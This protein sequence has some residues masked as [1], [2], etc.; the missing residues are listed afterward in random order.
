[1]EII[2]TFIAE[3]LSKFDFQYMLVVNIATYMIIKVIDIVNDEKAVPTWLKRAIAFIV[4]IAIGLV[5]VL[6]GNANFVTIFYSF[7]I[8]L[9]S[10]DT[11]FKPILNRLSGNLNYYKDNK[12]SNI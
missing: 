8:S 6:V 2:N 10:W 4:G 7:F 9:V 12:D 3:L 1:M 5:I 11:I